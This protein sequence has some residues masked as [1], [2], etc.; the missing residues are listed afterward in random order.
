MTQDAFA[1]HAEAARVQ[2][3]AVDEQRAREAKRAAVEAHNF[4]AQKAAQ[5]S[6]QKAQMFQHAMP[7]QQAQRQMKADLMAR[8][9]K[10]ELLM[11]AA[12]FERR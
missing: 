6:M 3:L 11:K 7:A 10:E 12:A 2:R 4:Q 1:R 8:A 5:V 9:S